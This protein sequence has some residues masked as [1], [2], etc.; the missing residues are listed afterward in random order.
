MAKVKFPL[1]MANGT[2]VRNLDELKENFD[3]KKVI[4]YFLD[5]KLQ[6]WL[7]DRY[8]DEEFEALSKLDENDSDLSIKL[9]SVFGIDSSN[10]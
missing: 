2:M 3:I 4:G 6:T 8:Y 7:E 1:E 9:C 5:G 10:V